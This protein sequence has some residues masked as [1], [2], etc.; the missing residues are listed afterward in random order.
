V[1]QLLTMS[2][3]LHWNFFRDYNN[4]P[5]DRVGDALSLPF[6]RRPGTWFE[7]HQSP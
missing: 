4:F 3:G 1:R 5:V 6:D 2:T 7:Y